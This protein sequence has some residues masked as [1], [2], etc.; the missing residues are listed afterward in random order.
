MGN[1][2]G[3]VVHA[4]NVHDAKSGIL[5]AQKACEK[6]PSIQAFCADAGY[7]GTFIDEVQ[8]QIQ[9]RVDI[10]EKIKPHEREKLLRRWIVERTFGWMSAARR[11]AKELENSVFIEEMM[12]IISCAA[13]LLRRL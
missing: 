7:R 5:A 3:V 4:T 12:N 13:V 1:L 8:Q 11:L 2:L 10:S 6:Y 9:R